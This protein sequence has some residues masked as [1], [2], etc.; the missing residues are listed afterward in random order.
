MSIHICGHYLSRDVLYNP[1]VHK[2]SGGRDIQSCIYLNM[3][4]GC[5]FCYGWRPRGLFTGCALR[6]S[7]LKTDCS[8]KW[9]LRAPA[10]SLEGL[11]RRWER[12]ER[13]GRE[14]ERTN[15]P[16]SL[17][18][19]NKTHFTTQQLLE[20]KHP[21]ILERHFTLQDKEMDIVILK[22]AVLHEWWR[23]LRFQW[24]FIWFKKLQKATHIHLDQH[25]WAPF[26]LFPN[27]YT[28]G[29][30]CVYSWVFNLKPLDVKFIFSMGNYSQIPLLTKPCGKL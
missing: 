25:R 4:Y 14:T 16:E 27:K 2:N 13:G 7:S 22:N 24:G 10:Q 29:L 8:A 28:L 23:L 30:R 15:R 26:S 5:A 9:L 12:E 18:F 1:L 20:R 11:L 19:L 17:S 3:D 21:L 6:L